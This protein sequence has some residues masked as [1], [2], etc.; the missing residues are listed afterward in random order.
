MP[1]IDTRGYTSA[2][3]ALELDGV[4]AGWL[5]TAEGGDATADVVQEKLGPDRVVRK[6]LGA[7]RYEEITVTCG[8]GMSKAF[9][10]WIANTLTGKY[11]RKN[12]AVIATDLNGK[13]VARLEFFNG[14]I[15]SI[16]FPALDGA[17][18]N[19]A[20]LTI[21]IAPEYTRT[22]KAS[23][24]AVAQ[25]APAVQKGW[26]ASN[27]RLT[28]PGL[29]CSKVSRIEAVTVKQE[30]ADD[31]IGETRDYQREPGAL[32]IPNLAVTLAEATAQ[33]WRDWFEDFVIRGNS[34]ADR[35]KTGQV[36]FLSHDLKTV[37]FAVTF[38]GLGIFKLA[39]VAS[40]ANAEVIARLKAELY[41]EEVRLTVGAKVATPP[42]K[43]VA[44]PDVVSAV[45]PGA[46]VPVRRGAVPGA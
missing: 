23:G 38:N 44:K 18:K 1:G 11:A 20:F 3:Y 15:E 39:R 31:E 6:H 28:I 2:R 27:F 33:T 37:L 26:I 35:E 9:Y 45:R 4:V 41:C 8:T 46:V 36:D 42:A 30:L 21:K 12:G 29:D 24:K 22:S 16:G 13:P 34:G 19:T 40:S 43:I 32:E 5:Q 10:D 25:P 14:L 17:S 7:V